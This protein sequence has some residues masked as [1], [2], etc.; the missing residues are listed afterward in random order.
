MDISELRLDEIFSRVITEAFDYSRSKRECIGLSDE[1]LILY[2]CSRV[3]GDFKSGRDFQQFNI[4][5]GKEKFPS[6][7]FSDALKS[8]R[9]LKM[10]KEVSGG[11]ELIISRL[12][13]ELK[14]D[15][16]ADFDY[17]NEYEVYACDGHFIEHACHTR[18]YDTKASQRRAGKLPKL[19][20]AGNLY[21]QNLRNGLLKSTAIP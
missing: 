13:N 8:F 18:T 1:N 2:S 16:L 14:V 4:E 20:A 11:S 15:Y 5:S 21:L 3:L 10:V 6:S 12:M 19:H 17:L 7:T 9:R